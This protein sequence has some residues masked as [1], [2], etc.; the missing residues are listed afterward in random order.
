M[1]SQG[2]QHGAH[3]LHVG[4]ANQ[5]VAGHIRAPA[6]RRTDARDDGV[7]LARRQQRT[8][9]PRHNDRE[10][11][12]KRG[13]GQKKTPQRFKIRRRADG[14]SQLTSEWPSHT[15]FW[16]TCRVQQPQHRTHTAPARNITN[17]AASHQTVNRYQWHPLNRQKKETVRSAC[18]TRNAAQSA[19]WR[20]VAA[21]ASR[22]RHS[23]KP[24]G[25]RHWAREEACVMHTTCHCVIGG[26]SGGGVRLKV[27]GG[28]ARGG[29]TAANAQGEAAVWLLPAANARQTHRWRECGRVVHAIRRFVDG[30][31]ITKPAV[32]TPS[33]EGSGVFWREVMDTITPPMCS[34]AT[35]KLGS[36]TTQTTT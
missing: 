16:F 17:G 5:E 3:V 29:G 10:H 4:R 26:F 33:R 30:T 15:D 21:P 28:R 27:C 2:T 8:A 18:A 1:G 23:T 31:V 14:V 20:A 22:T 7:R 12:D 24:D 6:H 36:L 34:V 9:P 13:G 32:N 11:N 19:P 25:E 35:A